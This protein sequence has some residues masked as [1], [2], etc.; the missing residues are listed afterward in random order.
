MYRLADLVVITVQR[1]FTVSGIDNLF[2][3]TLDIAFFFES[4]SD[5]VSNCANFDADWAYFAIAE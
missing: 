1:E 3:N 5:E 4:V 2:R